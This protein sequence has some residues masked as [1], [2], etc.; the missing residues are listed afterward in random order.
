MEKRLYRSRKY[1]V[2]AGVAGGLGEY[3]GIDPVLIRLLFVIITLTPALHPLGIIAYLVLWFAVPYDENKSAASA[4]PNIHE[5]SREKHAKS[6][7]H[8]G[9]II[10]GTAL[11][12]IGILLLGNNLFEQFDF[13]TT[14]PLVLVTV[15]L[16][17][18]FTAFGKKENN[19]VEQHES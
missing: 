19:G 9:G 15:G 12:T 11:L 8:T 10:W 7:S 17:L 18:L 1:K 13:G 4:E 3:F 2:V 16:A 6:E 14:W 5:E